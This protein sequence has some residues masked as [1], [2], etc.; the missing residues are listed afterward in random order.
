MSTGLALSCTTTSTT[1]LHS[2]QSG[3]LPW[4][5]RWSS[6][7]CVAAGAAEAARLRPPD[8]SLF[9]TA[10]RCFGS[11]RSVALL[12]KVVVM[13]ALLLLLLLL[14]PSLTPPL[15]AC[16]WCGRGCWVGFFVCCCC[17]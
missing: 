17:C 16:C 2:K 13:V 7:S 3:P 10:A 15:E 4:Q 14:Q 1:S 6:G 9:A 5:Q 8:E 12:V 11:A